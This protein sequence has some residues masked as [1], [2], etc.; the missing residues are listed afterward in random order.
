MGVSRGINN[1]KVIKQAKPNSIGSNI[2]LMALQS[3]QVAA[4]FNKLAEIVGGMAPLKFEVRTARTSKN[5]IARQIIEYFTA[6]GLLAPSEFKKGYVMKIDGD[7]KIT[8]YR[9]AD[10]ETWRGSIPYEFYAKGNGHQWKIKGNIKYEPIMARVNPKAISYNI[11]AEFIDYRNQTSRNVPDNDELTRW[12]KIPEAK[13]ISGE[14]IY[15]HGS[16]WNPYVVNTAK[17]TLG[18]YLGISPKTIGCVKDKIERNDSIKSNNDINYG[19]IQ[20]YRK[21]SKTNT[22]Y[23]FKIIFRKQPNFSSIEYMFELVPIVPKS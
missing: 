1:I 5:D 10:K 13:V 6:N 7:T 11:N 4:K 15:F 23:E 2:S 9:G 3:D 12:K 14:K 22:L 16:F 17:I 21:N 19:T 8:P 20:L 18:K